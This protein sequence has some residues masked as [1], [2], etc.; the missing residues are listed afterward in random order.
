MEMWM[1]THSVSCPPLFSDEVAQFM[2]V[3]YR[4]GLPHVTSFTTNSFRSFHPFDTPHCT[5]MLRAHIQYR[6]EAIRASG[7]AGPFLKLH[8]IPA[9]L[10]SLATGKY[11]RRTAQLPPLSLAL[12]LPITSAQ[13]CVLPCVA[14]NYLIN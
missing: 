10:T 9:L 14:V 6:G 11:K 12:S 1:R 2:F 5:H 3:L 8:W 13:M 4:H 7:R